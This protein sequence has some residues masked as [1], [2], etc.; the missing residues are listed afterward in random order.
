MTENNPYEEL[1]PIQTSMDNINNPIVQQ[2][3]ADNKVGIYWDEWIE[4]V[5]FMAIRYTSGNDTPSSWDEIKLR[6]MYQDLQ[7][8]TYTDIQQAIIKL[9]AEGRTFA[10]NSSQ[11]I[12]K[13]NALNAPQVMSA[14]QYKRIAGGQ[15]SE[16]KGGG[17]HEF[18]DWGW[19][20]DEQG[21][22]KF[23]EV[24][25]KVAGPNMPTC[26]AERWKELPSPMNMSMHP[27][28]HMTRER[29]IQSMKQLKLSQNK[30][31]ELLEYRNK[32]LT[33]EEVEK[34]GIKYAK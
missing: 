32:L 30:Q 33:E 22:P 19:F 11:I 23:M 5:Q 6:A 21:Y 7:Y 8:F 20:F 18:T 26:L 16:C 14:N 28:F 10:P 25:C 29:F 15:Y 1:Q 27:G 9:H 12:G 4:C 3:K 2:V 31:D 34:L 24:C 13:L 17:D